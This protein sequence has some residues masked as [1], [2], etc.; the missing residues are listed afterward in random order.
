MRTVLKDLPLHGKYFVHKEGNGLFGFLEL[1]TLV[2]LGVA[3]CFVF[4]FEPFD[5]PFQ[6]LNF[7]FHQVGGRW[8]QGDR[9][10]RWES[11]VNINVLLSLLHIKYLIKQLIS[12][13]W[14]ILSVVIMLGFILMRSVPHICINTIFFPLCLDVFMK[15]SYILALNSAL[16]CRIWIFHIWLGLFSNHSWQFILIDFF[17]GVFSLLKEW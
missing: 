17:I 3:Q 12:I 10:L 13:L 14:D 1:C 6:I 11:G 8:F 15:Q 9:R 4:L 7:D 2:L 16:I 5:F